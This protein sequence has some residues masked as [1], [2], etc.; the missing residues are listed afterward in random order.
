MFWAICGAAL[1]IGFRRI[2]GA[3]RSVQKYPALY[4][5]DLASVGVALAMALLL[6]Y[7]VG[8][9]SARPETASV[10]FWS[11]VQYLAICALVFPLSGL[12]SRNW[13]YGSISDL[14][15][16]LRAVLLTSLLL[17]TLLF[18]STRLTDIPRTVVPM[19]TP[20]SAS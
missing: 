2:R 15:I 3:V 10:L 6:R 7:G 12:Y 14:F 13:K 16:I 1:D 18:F 17:V 4:L 9:L 20:S 5:T 8:E 11:G 19:T